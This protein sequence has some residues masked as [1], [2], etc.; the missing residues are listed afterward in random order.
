MYREILGKRAALVSTDIPQILCS[1]HFF[2]DFSAV[3]IVYNC[4][5]KQQTVP[6]QVE[7]NWNIEAF[8]SDTANAA[9]QNGNITL[10]PGAGICFILKKS[11]DPAAS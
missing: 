2:D 1:D 7:K 10:P 3:S 4:T 9:W 6:L 5:S 8:Y 11:A